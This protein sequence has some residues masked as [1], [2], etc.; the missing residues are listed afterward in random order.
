MGVYTKEN[1]NHQ[2]GYYE[3]N[4][5][6]ETK[7][8]HKKECDINNIM[9][10]YQKTGL[11]SHIAKYEPSYQDAPDIDYHMAMNKIA[12]VDEVFMELPSTVRKHFENDPGKFLE[13][14]D[15]PDNVDQ[16]RE[17]GLCKP[18]QA[19]ESSDPVGEP[20]L[21]PETPSEDN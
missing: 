10:K 8:S 20:T 15:D 7:Q 14:V 19:S 4:E 16:L 6:S 5:P 1:F 2:A 12:Q 17:W 18:L 21:T 11:C 13:F 3:N 9:A